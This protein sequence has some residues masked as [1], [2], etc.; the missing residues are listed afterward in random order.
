[1]QGNPGMSVT[2]ILTEGGSVK[3]A[4]LV[5]LLRGLLIAPILLLLARHLN[6]AALGLY[7]L[8]VATD[9]LDGWLARRGGRT[10][11]FGA[12]LDAVI[13]NL[14]SVA[15]A[16]FLW[17]AQPE[18]FRDHPLALTV[19]FGFPLAYLAIAWAMTGR[20]LM[21]HF[22]S[23]RLGALLLFALWPVVALTGWG[24]LVPVTAAVVGASR[25][26]QILFMA[27]GGRDQDARHL[28]QAVTLSAESGAAE[29]ERAP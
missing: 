23:A 21:F 22:H 27:R 4:N 7:V 26:E 1:M 6:A 12:S 25:I 3:T 10:S 29:P 15:I 18:L 28:F 13:D 9:G 17:L 14:F 19:L 11:A 20:V 2:Y 8:A 16:G 5:S 24:W